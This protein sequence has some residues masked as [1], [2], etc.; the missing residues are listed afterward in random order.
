VA[1]ERNTRLTVARRRR[2]YTVFPSTKSAVIV[3]GQGPLWVRSFGST[4]P[5]G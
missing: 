2:L 5:P 3:E 1:G 4:K